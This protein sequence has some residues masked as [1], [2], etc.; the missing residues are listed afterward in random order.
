[1]TT[2]RKMIVTCDDAT[3]IDCAFYD[4]ASN[5]IPE[6][7]EYDAIAELTPISSTLGDFDYGDAANGSDF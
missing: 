7:M 5:A 1:M 3:R 4:F 6:K 2:T